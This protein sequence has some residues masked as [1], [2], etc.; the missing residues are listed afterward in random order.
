MTTTTTAHRY[1]AATALT[2][3]SLMTLDTYAHAFDELDPDERLN[4]EAQIG[5]ARRCEDVPVSYLADEPAA[6]ANETPAKR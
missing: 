1:D 3:L 2:Q 4:A 5:R 6:G